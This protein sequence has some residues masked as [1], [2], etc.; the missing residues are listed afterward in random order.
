MAT[1]PDKLPGFWLDWLTITDPDVIA[2]SGSDRHPILRR[3]GPEDSVDGAYLV[4][5]AEE[6]ASTDDYE[7]DDYVRVEVGL[8]SGATAWVY[9]AAEDR[10]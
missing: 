9:V 6:L 10:A 7:V 8:T 5:D 4:L 3:G 1:V 2:A